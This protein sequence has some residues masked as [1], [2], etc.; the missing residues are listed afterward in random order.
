MITH[1][2]LSYIAFKIKWVF[3]FRESLMC[4]RLVGCFF[5]SMRRYSEVIVFVVATVRGGVLQCLNLNHIQFDFFLMFSLVVG[6]YWNWKM[7]GH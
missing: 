1:G 3:A 6:G 5:F 7:A 4:M 2:A